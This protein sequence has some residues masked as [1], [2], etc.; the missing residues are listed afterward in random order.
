MWQRLREEAY[1]QG[2]VWNRRKSGE[3]YAELLTITA[4]RNQR[5]EVENYVGL[6]SDITR[7]KEHERELERIANYDALTG[8]PNRRLLADRLHQA[9]ALSQR[10]GSTLAVVYLDLDGFKAVNDQHGHECGDELLIAIARRM[11]Q[12]VRDSDTICRLGGDEFVAVL[13]D[14][15]DGSACM[16]FLSR[17][18]DACA[19]AVNIGGRL[20]QV[21]ASIG[22][23]LY[24][25]HSEVDADQLMRQA[26]QAMYEAKLA[27]KNRFHLFDAEQ[28]RSTISR[29]AQLD[30]IRRALAQEE[31]VLYYQPIVNLRLG[32][33]VAAEALIRW[34]H[35][36]RGLLSP[37]EFLP[38]I[39]DDPLAV[40]LGEWVLEAALR[41][42]EAWQDA[43]LH[44]VSSVNIGSRQLQQ[45]D[46]VERLKALLDAHP[47]VTPAR[48]KLEVLETSAL[49]DIT[50]V[51]RI[52]AECAALGVSFALDD[53]GTGYSSLLYLKRLPAAQIKID[54][55]FVRNMLED[56]D[57]LA[58]LE[59]VLGLAAAFRRDAIAEGVESEAHARML[60]QLGC[61]LAQGYGIA[62]PMPAQALPGWVAGWRPA[63]GLMS[64]PALERDALP[65]LAAQ[66]E[67]RAWARRMAE[68]LDGAADHAPAV[69]AAQ[70]TLLAL[71]ATRALCH[72]VQ[73]EAAQLVA[74]RRG[75]R[76]AALREGR[77]SLT[78]LLA[79]L[80][81][82]L[83]ALLDV[84]E[85]NRVY[86]KT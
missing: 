12:S 22:V 4:L 63:P 45:P 60:L 61:Q 77:A 65:L 79:Q 64:V 67:Y 23:A 72:A 54:Q 35:P 24:P 15:P 43:G 21:S 36:R 38:L 40:Q 13:Q 37:A 27:G 59:G 82:E 84:P 33:V 58:I 16:P 32:R 75:R 85:E 26:D 30:A 48:L 3:V 83:A 68:Y 69:P 39:E 80:G 28:Q 14:L 76:T 81:A 86:L 19:R 1:W 6:F 8:L 10:R 78:A 18:L 34:Q 31:F 53:F 55:G 29:H 52:M 62:R 41:Q 5:G 11:K 47:G 25:Q 51:S 49:E 17:L 71:A 44:I 73:L 56:P 7:Q 57:D 2:E 74:H 50:H 70:A 9:L 66:V 46:F 42:Q 20:L